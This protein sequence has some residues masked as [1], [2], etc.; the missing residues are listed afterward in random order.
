M[1]IVRP[2]LSVAA[3]GLLLSLCVRV[4][5][6]IYPFAKYLKNIEPI[7]FIFGGKRSPDPGRKPFDFE[8]KK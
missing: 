7:N 6:Y 5:P 8:S 4:C 2:Q 1:L 3:R